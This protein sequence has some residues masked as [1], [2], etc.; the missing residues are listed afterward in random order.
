MIVLTA[1]F[2]VMMP[3]NCEEIMFMI[4][5]LTNLD[6]FGTES[7]IVSIFGFKDTEPFNKQFYLAGFE[8][9]NF[10]IEL[11]P[12]MFLIFGFV[13]MCLLKKI[14]SYVVL[15][16]LGPDNAVTRLIFRPIPLRITILR[17][18][19]EGCIDMG[20]VAMICTMKT[21]LEN[22][23]SFWGSVAQI[24]AYI[25]LLCLFC[26]PIYMGY[27]TNRFLKD[28]E[29]AKNRLLYE[30]CFSELNPNSKSALNYS[31]VFFG[32]RYLMVLVLIL[33]P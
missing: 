2:S 5:K 9:S 13:V 25:C 31:R 1:L 16:I 4:M 22:F 24:M 7:L 17:F 29:S 32:R 19:L 3:A 28:P 30:E 11:G 21:K 15:E 23:D 18:F 14:L 10:F 20:L 27:L 12:I 8:S 33:L 26:A 6:I